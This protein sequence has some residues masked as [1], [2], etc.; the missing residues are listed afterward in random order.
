[1]KAFAIIVDLKLNFKRNSNQLKIYEVKVSNDILTGFIRRYYTINTEIYKLAGKGRGGVNRQ[2]LL[3]YLFKVSH[4][5]LTTKD[6]G[7][8]AVLPIDRLCSYANIKDAIPGHKKQN[9]DRILKSLQLSNFKFEYQ[10][11]NI[12]SSYKYMVKLDFSSPFVQIESLPVHSFY[13]QLFTNLRSLFLSKVV[14][15]TENEPI[16]FQLWLSDNSQH[17][18][19]KSSILAGAY[20]NC[21][22]LKI[23]NASATELIKSGD[24]LNNNS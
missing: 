2:G 12:N 14:K 11:V 21:L 15:G 4:I 16:L 6:G 3:L 13:N 7:N 10:F 23:T 17:L 19:E 22:D 1:M 9:L 8:S 24:I 20:R 5:L 18:A